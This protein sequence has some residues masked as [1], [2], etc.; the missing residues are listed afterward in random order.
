MVCE[1]LGFSV[2]VVV[3]VVFVVI[4]HLSKGESA[5]VNYGFIFWGILCKLGNICTLESQKWLRDNSLT[6]YICIV[7]NR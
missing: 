6:P 4:V 5:N 1:N 7:A 2:F 3:V